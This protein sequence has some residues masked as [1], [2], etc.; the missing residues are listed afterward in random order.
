MMN[1]DTCVPNGSTVTARA[2]YDCDV[3]PPVVGPS[4]PEVAR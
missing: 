3:A 2:E 4:I 1:T